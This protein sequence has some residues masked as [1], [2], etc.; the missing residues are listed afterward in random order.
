[1]N[2]SSYQLDPSH[3]ANKGKN[4]NWKQVEKNAAHRESM[5][6]C[7]RSAG[8]PLAEKVVPPPVSEFDRLCRD[9]ARFEEDRELRR[10]VGT[11][12]HQAEE[13]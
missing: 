13:R 12:S 9:R 6:P 5:L 4:V 1:M 2:D 11:L 10:R 8:Q 7:S 3:P